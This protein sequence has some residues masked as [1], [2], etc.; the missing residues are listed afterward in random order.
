MPAKCDAR[1]GRCHKSGLIVVSSAED[2]A[3]GSS[4][5][6]YLY[7]QSGLKDFIAHSYN[8]SLNYVE[9]TTA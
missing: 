9:P 1:G 8:T 7:G 4:P 6:L 5:P 3:S 2:S